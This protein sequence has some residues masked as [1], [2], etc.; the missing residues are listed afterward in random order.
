[1]GQQLILVRD[2]VVIGDVVVEE[3]REVGNV[4]HVGGGAQ[5]FLLGTQL[6]GFLCVLEGGD[7]VHPA[8]IGFGLGHGWGQG[9][10][11][12]A[13]FVPHAAG[14]VCHVDACLS[15]VDVVDIRYVRDSTVH[16]ISGRIHHICG[17]SGRVIVIDIGYGIQPGL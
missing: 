9:V 8:V 5:V 6:G 17:I 7:R 1:M 3:G 10:K 12:S 11:S 2:A 16:L 14:V 13:Q 15:A 4:E